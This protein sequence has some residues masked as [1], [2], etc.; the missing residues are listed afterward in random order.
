MHREK[1]VPIRLVSGTATAHGW[2]DSVGY[3]RRNEGRVKERG[4]IRVARPQAGA[5]RGRSIRSMRTT[6]TRKGLFAFRS[7]EWE[8]GPAGFRPP[9]KPRRTP[10]IGNPSAAAFSPEGTRILAPMPCKSG[11]R[12]EGA[13]RPRSSGFGGQKGDKKLTETAES[14]VNV[15]A[16]AKGRVGPQD[17]QSGGSRN[18]P[19]LAGPLIR[20]ESGSLNTEGTEVT[21]G[22]SGAIRSARF[23]P[24]AQNSSRPGASRSPGL[25]LG[26]RYPEGAVQ[27]PSIRPVESPWRCRPETPIRSSMLR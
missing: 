10:G 8:S 12:S 15:K 6:E 22:R 11:A 13:H 2:G 5:N 21:E 17:R 16:A 3:A 1:H 4:G 23:L 25:A 18:R 7:H 27:I 14:L 26:G 19:R 9:G 20:Q 24:C